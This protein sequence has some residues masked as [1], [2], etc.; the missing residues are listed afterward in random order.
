MKKISI[1]LFAIIISSCSSMESDANKVCEFSELNFKK[2]ELSVAAMS[3]D[4]KVQKELK[5]VDDKIGEM[6]KDIEK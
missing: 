4:K 3:G 1:F 2:I 5:E 6:E